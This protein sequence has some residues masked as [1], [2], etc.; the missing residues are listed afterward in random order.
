MLDHHSSITK[1]HTVVLLAVCDTHYR[2]V[3]VDVGGADRQSDDGVLSNSLFG[4]AL[5]NGSLRL[6]DSR[7]LPGLPC[8]SLPYVFV[9]DEAFPL[10]QNVMRP[11]PGRNLPQ[12][13]AI[14]NYRLS[15]A[16][17]IIENTFG[18]L[19]SR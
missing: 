11:Y 7:R 9:G 6:P 17:R 16:R 10:K 1:A 2:F 3:M 4:R 8:S 19:A 15:R 13:Q 14:Y 12:A 5:E 18:I